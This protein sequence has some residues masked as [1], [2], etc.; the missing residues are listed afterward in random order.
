MPKDRLADKGFL[1]VNALTIDHLVAATAPERLIP[2]ELWKGWVADLRNSSSRLKLMA[3]IAESINLTWPANRKKEKLSDYLVDSLH[4]MSSIRGFG[5][6]KTRI[7]ILCVAAAAIGSRNDYMGITSAGQGQFVLEVPATGH[8]P[9]GSVLAMTILDLLDITQDQE[10]LVVE[11]L[12]GE[13]FSALAISPDVLSRLRRFGVYVDDTLES[14]LFLSLSYLSAIWGDSRDLES[15]VAAVVDL[16]ERKLNCSV[17][18]NI[19][20]G[21]RGEKF[22]DKA[23]GNIL[24]TLPI[25]N[26]VIPS[27]DVDRLRT[28]GFRRWDDLLSL[29]EYDIVKRFGSLQEAL[30][31]LLFLWIIRPRI[32]A[33]L[34]AME[35]ATKD[36]EAWSSFESLMHSLSEKLFRQ[37]RDVDL[38]LSR[39][40]WNGHPPK[41]LE[42]IGAL[43]GLSRERVRQVESKGLE[44]I[45]RKSS[46]EVLLPLW[47]TILSFVEI[48]EVLSVTELAETLQT[49]FGW[50]DR[51]SEA[52]LTNLLSSAFADHLEA[53]GLEI[54]DGFVYKRRCLCLNCSVVLDGIL[55]ELSEADA[56]SM[57]QIL[58][59][60]LGFCETRGITGLCYGMPSRSVIEFFVARNGDAAG[61]SLDGDNL[62]N[63]EWLTLQQGS[64]LSA[65][66]TLLG[67]SD[68][69]LHFTVIYE[70]LARI[71]TED[72]GLTAHNVHAALGRSASVLL[73]DRGTYIHKEKAPFPFGLVRQI[74]EWLEAR[75]QGEVPFI[76]VFGAFE[77]FQQRCTEAGIPS[78]SALYSCL[79]VSADP[80]FVYPKYPYVYLSSTYNGRLALC[81]VFEDFVRSSKTEVSHH[82]MK[83]FAIER[84]NIKKVML[85]QYL[86]RTPNI[87]RTAAGYVHIDSL[88]IDKTGLREVISY[89]DTFL[90][91]DRHMSAA[92]VFADREV[93]CRS[94]GIDDPI[95]L[96]SILQ[97]YASDHLRLARY[98]QIQAGA[99]KAE[100]EAKGIIGNIIEYIKK[101]ARPCAYQELYD[102]FCDRLGYSKNTVYSVRN[103][104]SIY[105]FLPSCLIH[106]DALGL[107]DTVYAE[108]EGI[109]RRIYDRE[110]AVGRCYGL[111]ETIMELSELPPLINGFY[112]TDQLLSDILSRSEGFIFLGNTKAAFVA[113]PNPYGITTF[114]D[115]C[116]RLLVTEHGGAANLEEFSER[117][118]D[119]GII[120]GGIRQNMLGTSSKVFIHGRE[121]VAA[122]GC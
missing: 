63:K 93:T 121:I 68:E 14:I 61:I 76:N 119:L 46:F 82:C 11:L 47:L 56:V 59:K 115:F 85:N 73:W 5:K 89:I 7:A 111:I 22:F 91:K 90:S 17:V 81:S 33:I 86:D 65:I 106:R 74:E 25:T 95:L 4:D 43:H 30:G 72:T 66:E 70:R 58:D 19:K 44:A 23:Y 6:T 114:E 9:R 39:M 26:A 80:L 108:I 38:F 113:N 21:P 78:E 48:R 97:V 31:F 84:L 88:S 1:T 10:P 18:F 122:N 16:V 42:Q 71:R 64:L 109:S 20:E 103:H 27:E 15:A 117:L 104:G 40:G 2:D 28:L 36:R 87:L 102:Y 112:W 96:Y 32:D 37:K 55:K 120:A 13:T 52:G 3:E 60:L 105:T 79:R 92:R 107:S 35:S 51:P 53:A 29:S 94:M 12:E 8:V 69:P 98:P 77:A 45:G 110:L 75:L 101:K 50:S 49:H 99:E 116:F 34:D 67:R 54:L 118:I 83:E 57:N 41:T 24:G 100:T 62:Y